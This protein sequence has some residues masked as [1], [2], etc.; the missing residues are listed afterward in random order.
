MFKTRYT[1]AL[2]STMATL[3]GGNLVF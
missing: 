1:I 3:I 2:Y